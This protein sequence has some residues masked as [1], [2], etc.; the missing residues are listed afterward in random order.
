MRRCLAI[1]RYGRA[2]RIGISSHGQGD[3]K[4]SHPQAS[5]PWP[6]HDQ[7]DRKGRPYYIRMRCWGDGCQECFQVTENA[8]PPE[9]EDGWA[10][11]VP[12]EVTI[13]IS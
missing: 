7:G 4:G 6:H 3:R 12:P 9:S 1:D 11:T 5:A 2:G 10:F 13:M 8:V